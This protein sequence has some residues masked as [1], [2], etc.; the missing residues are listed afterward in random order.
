MFL[1]QQLSDLDFR[2]SVL[3]LGFSEE[4]QGAL[5][6]FYK[7]KKQEICEVLSRRTLDLPHYR[8]LEWRFEVQVKSINGFYASLSLLALNK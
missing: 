6:L 8:D 3:T 7:G 2:D 5:E 4:H 1:F